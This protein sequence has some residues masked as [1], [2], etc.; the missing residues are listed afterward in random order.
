MI[1]SSLG[2]YEILELLLCVM[3]GGCSPSA[4]LADFAERA[5]DARNFGHPDSVLFWSPDQQLA[6]F[7]NYDRI[8]ATRAIP[9]S[10]NP[11][12]L[13]ER[14]RDLSR[15]R[16][17]VDGD[18]FDLRGFKE[19][20]H[21]VGL[22]A[23]KDGAIVLEEY[24]RGNTPTT[25]WVSYSVAKSVVSLLLGAAVRD[26][27]I[28]GVDDPVTDYL[29]LL[30]GT[31]YEGVT[32]RDALRMSSGVAWNEDYEDPDSDVSKE[33]GLTALE[34]LR[35]L[36]AHP[37]VA[38]PGQRFN[39]NTGETHLVGGVVRAAIGNN[40]STY[41]ATKI[42]E[43]FGMESDANWRLV[44]PGGA[45]HGGCCISAT[46]RDYGRIGLFALS[47]GVLPDG[48]HVL[49]QGWMDESTTPSPANDGYGYLWWLR[50]GG[51]YN[52]LGIFGQ[53]IS[54]DPTENLI[55]VTHGVW[56]RAT[57]SDFS[58]HRGAFFAALTLALQ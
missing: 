28:T 53:A 25:K 58:A 8:F 20:N 40:L 19:H 26:G 51:V 27:Y 50:E 21:V 3:C 18:T 37:R 1:R 32:I 4:D 33:I 14:L 23:I 29:P 55:I 17:E 31:S 10:H 52:A 57:G 6:S 48:R 36:G 49:P 13:P 56:P 41:L 39:Y 30:M 7:R 42:W 47:G 9:A 5:D 2:R 54:I 35:Y 16:Y 43:P 22:L 11:L 38:A 44:E 15:V 46:L 12:A 45:E 24:E 34:R